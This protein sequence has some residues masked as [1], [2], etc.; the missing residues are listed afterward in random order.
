MNHTL[1]QTR[2]FTTNKVKARRKVEG[3]AAEQFFFDV[4]SSSL[5]MDPMCTKAGPAGAMRALQNEP[6]PFSPE[7]RPGGGS[8][9]TNGVS[10]GTASTKRSCRLGKQELRLGKQEPKEE[11]LRKQMQR[12]CGH[13]K[14]GLCL[15]YTRSRIWSRTCPGRPAGRWSG[16]A[17]TTRRCRQRQGVSCTIW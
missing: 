8:C 10:R 16:V 1:I 5:R 12:S 11:H 17:C 4:S 9:G 6:A 15:V 2:N 3:K 7:R 13:G 14:P